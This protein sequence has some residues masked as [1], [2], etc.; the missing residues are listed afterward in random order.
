MEMDKQPKEL[1]ANAEDDDLKVF[2]R[3][4]PCEL[5]KDDL[6]LVAGGVR[7]HWDPMG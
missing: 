4:S 7:G 6:E 3:T 1:I 5:A 2:V